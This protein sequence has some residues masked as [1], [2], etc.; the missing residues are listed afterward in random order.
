MVVGKALWNGSFGRLRLTSQNII[1]TDP[2]ETGHEVVN[3]MGDLR[4]VCNVLVRD[5]L[6]IN[7]LVSAR[8]GWQYNIRTDPAVFG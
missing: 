1:K 2:S 3:W 5:P 8:R 7:P 6:G 4:I